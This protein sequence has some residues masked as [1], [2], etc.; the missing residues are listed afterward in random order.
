MTVKRIRLDTYHRAF[1]A[2]AVVSSFVALLTLFLKDEFDR[3]QGDKDVPRLD[4]GFVFATIGA[5]ILGSV[6]I[7]YFF[8]WL[9]G[10]G[11]GMLS[12]TREAEEN[13][14]YVARLRRLLQ[15][16]AASSAT[17]SNEGS[18]ELPE[19]TPE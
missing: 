8:Y 1:W 7:Y 5:S 12:D 3:L 13:D 17:A 11:G 14:A 18:G 15:L 16:P 10:F 6:V 4:V 2:Q 9:I 19:V